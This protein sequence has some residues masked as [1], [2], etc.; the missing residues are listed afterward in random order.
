MGREGESVG[1]DV[2]AC[3]EEAITPLLERNRVIQETRSDHRLRRGRGKMEGGTGNA[4][5]G[6]RENEERDV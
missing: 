2:V 3:I 6:R 4:E 5:R 1:S